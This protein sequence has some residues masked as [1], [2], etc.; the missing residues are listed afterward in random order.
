MI[1]RWF[2]FKGFICMFNHKYPSPIGELA[3]PWRRVQV[4]KR[5][6]DGFGCFGGLVTS[7]GSEGSPTEPSKS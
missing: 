4:V 7:A 6:Q 3:E 5:L 2:I 1:I